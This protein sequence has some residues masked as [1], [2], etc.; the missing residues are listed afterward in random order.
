MLDVAVGLYSFPHCHCTI[1]ILQTSA[2][3]HSIPGKT[4][5]AQ[6]VEHK[7]Q[8]GTGWDSVLPGGAWWHYLPGAASGILSPL[9]LQFPFM[10]LLLLASSLPAL[11]FTPT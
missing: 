10:L 11:F 5:T 1:L 6:E 7:T 4:L 3:H 8:D 9:K 2:C